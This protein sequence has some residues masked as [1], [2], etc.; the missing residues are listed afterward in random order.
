MST[1]TKRNFNIYKLTETAVLIA[2]I[3]IMDKTILGSIPT[4]G[5]KITL[6]S[7]PVAVAA[8]TI[9]PISGLICG[10][11]WGGLSFLG[12]VH[13]SSPL[14]GTLFQV[15]P[16]ALAFTA[17]IPRILVGVLVAY[18]FRLLHNKCKLKSISYY[19]SSLCAPL[20]N[21]ILFMTCIVLFYYNSDY[22][23][24]KVSELGA[25]NP[26][27][28]VLLFVGFNGLLEAI[29]GLTI[30]GVITHTLSKALANHENKQ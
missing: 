2:I 18:I 19:I 23:Q 11:V 13:G 24:S 22:I 10:F 27:T 26:F 9:G 7:I 21:T 12:G 6:I 30:G 1:S 29:A 5:F 4:L 16:F 3:I 14:M 20:L 17:F 8:I 28:F 25:T 15:N